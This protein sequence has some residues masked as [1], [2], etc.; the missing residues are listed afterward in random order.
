MSI[1]R[2]YPSLSVGHLVIGIIS[3]SGHMIISQYQYHNVITS[4]IFDIEEGES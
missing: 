3:E 4:S 1:L 2:V